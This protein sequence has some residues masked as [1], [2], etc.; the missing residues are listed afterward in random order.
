M[1]QIPQHIVQQF[2]LDQLLAE[3]MTYFFLDQTIDLMIRP[4]LPN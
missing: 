2:R 4:E 1:N 3:N